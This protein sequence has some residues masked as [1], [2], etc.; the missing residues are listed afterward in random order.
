MLIVLTY[1]GLSN[2]TPCFLLFL[3]TC[4]SSALPLALFSLFC[5]S[6]LVVQT[7]PTCAAVTQCCVWLFC[8]LSFTSKE[9]EWNGSVCSVAWLFNLSWCAVKPRQMECLHWNYLTVS[10]SSRNQNT[11]KWVWEDVKETPFRIPLP[12]S[13][14]FQSFI[15]VRSFKPAK[16]NCCSKPGRIEKRLHGS[17]EHF[18]PSILLG[19]VSVWSW[20][21]LKSF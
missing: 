21:F 20:A 8:T 12:N 14:C 10:G 5:G 9:M 17:L 11:V 19:Y 6:S 1:R 15:P 4:S 7:W 18:P 16:Q 2:C 13:F 3:N